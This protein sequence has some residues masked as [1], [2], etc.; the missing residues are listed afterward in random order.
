[1][2]P[3]EKCKEFFPFEKQ[4]SQQP[5]EQAE[6]PVPGGGGGG[7]PRVNGLLKV[8]RPSPGGAASLGFPGILGSHTTSHKTFPV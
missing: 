6:L 2:S 1:M 4:S 8:S 3:P 7:A 5:G